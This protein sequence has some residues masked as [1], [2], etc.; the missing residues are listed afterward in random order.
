MS[1]L[2]AVLAQISAPLVQSLREMESTLS[3]LMHALA[4]VPAQIS[5]LP[6]LLRKLNL[7]AEKSTAAGFP[8]AVF[9][10]NTDFQ[11]I[12]TAL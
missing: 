1:A 9:L 7:H 3:M 10:F 2:A 11:T 8:A 12:V 4:A 6:A 5:A